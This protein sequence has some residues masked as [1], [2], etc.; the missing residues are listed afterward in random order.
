[1]FFNEQND[2]R[3]QEYEHWTSRESMYI[4]SVDPLTI[5]YSIIYRVQKL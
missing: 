1:M 4:S 3:G 2:A 5:W